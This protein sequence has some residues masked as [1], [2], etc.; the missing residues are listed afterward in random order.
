MD[1]VRAA[2]RAITEAAQSRLTGISAARDDFGPDLYAARLDPRLSQLME[3]KPI[4]TDF[5]LG[6]CPASPGDQLRD[7]VVSLKKRGIR[8]IVA[9]PLGGEEF[10]ISVV[11]MIVPDLEDPPDSPHRVLGRR[12][13][14]AMMGQA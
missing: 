3:A 10:G 13:V 9:V 14:N 1:P 2:I 8:Q 11:K 4:L 5:T 12:A 7:V 6:P